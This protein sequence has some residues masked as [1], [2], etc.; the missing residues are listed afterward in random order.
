MGHQLTSKD[1]EHR[2]WITEQKNDLR[3][4]RQRMDELRVRIAIRL[5]GSRG[6]RDVRQLEMIQSDL[7]LA[8]MIIGKAEER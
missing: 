6:E 4:I 2:R 8:G 7:E 1:W 3:K 5:N